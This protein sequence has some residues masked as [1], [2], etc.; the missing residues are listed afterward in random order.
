M[1]YHVVTFCFVF[2]NE[3]HEQNRVKREK[4]K[5][6]RTNINNGSKVSKSGTWQFPPWASFWFLLGCLG[7]LPDFEVILFS[8]CLL[9]RR[10]QLLFFLN[11]AK[12]L[13]PKIWEI[14]S[15]F[16]QS[17]FLFQTCKNCC[18]WKVHFLIKLQGTFYIHV[19]SI[20]SL[21]AFVMPELPFQKTESCPVWNYLVVAVA[22]KI[23]LN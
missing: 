22:Q 20:Q 11:K 1:L 16:S 19:S 12:L 21:C 18:L 9:L 8:S 5:S 14:S 3:K 4:K 2:I 17:Y 7:A 10:K 15:D 6:P 13:N 23:L